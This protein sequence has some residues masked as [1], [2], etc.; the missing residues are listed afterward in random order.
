MRRIARQPH[1]DVCHLFMNDPSATESPHPAFW[2]PSGCAVQP[3][4]FKDVLLC[5]GESVSW[6]QICWNFGGSLEKDTIWL[7]LANDNQI[8]EPFQERGE[9]DLPKRLQYGAHS[10]LLHTMV[11]HCLVNVGFFCTKLFV[12]FSSNL[13]Q[14]LVVIC[15]TT[16]DFLLY[17]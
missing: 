2:A 17:H 13:F 11:C 15:W 14:I 3:S 8:A 1:P 6:A 10:A 4:L 16:Y 7:G 5:K 9:L 12:R